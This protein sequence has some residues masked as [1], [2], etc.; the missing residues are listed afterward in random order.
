MEREL[1]LARYQESVAWASEVPD[2]RVTIYN[3]GGD[4]FSP[5]PGARAFSLPNIGNEGHSYVHHILTHWEELAEWTVFSQADPFPHTTNF[6]KRLE[7][8]G[9]GMVWYGHG[10]PDELPCGHPN[11]G[12]PTP[13]IYTRLTGNP[14]PKKF[15]FAAGGLFGASRLLI[16]SRP[17]QMY[18]EIKDY[19]ESPGTPGA[20][21]PGWVLERLWGHLLLDPLNRKYE[22]P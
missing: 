16:H 1:V 11:A 15:S 20:S 7:E 17:Q 18:Q 8:G 6:R 22:D 5:P 4:P 10:F 19:L 12:L 3:K 9:E 21:I 13:E 14:C 2:Y